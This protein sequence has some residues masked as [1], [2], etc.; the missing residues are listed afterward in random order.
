MKKIIQFSKSQEGLYSIKKDFY[1]NNL[2]NLKKSIQ[3]NKF[4]N[5]QPLRTKCK[6]CNIKKSKKS[7]TSF[8]TNYFICKKCFHVNGNHE[9]NKKF[10]NYLYK[11]NRGKKYAKNY[12]ANYSSRLKYIYIPKIKFLKKVIG[13]KI[14][15]MDIGAG[16]GHFLKACK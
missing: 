11:S 5:K 9:D 14:D 13:S 2:L 12:L 3:T 1:L 6:N 7:F 16:A 8:N 10:I 4:Y 15:I